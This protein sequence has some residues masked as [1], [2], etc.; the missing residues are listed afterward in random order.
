MVMHLGV[1]D[2][3]IEQRRR[4][5]SSKNLEPP[6]RREEPLTDEPDLVLD[7][8]LPPQPDAGVQATGSTR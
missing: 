5:S 7:L 8:P 1:G 4:S 3:F 6:E 2:A